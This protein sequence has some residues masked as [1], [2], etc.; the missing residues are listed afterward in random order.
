MGDDRSGTRL[1]GAPA[2]DRIT[3]AADA[4]AALHEE[5]P[6]SPGD[7]VLTVGFAPAPVSGTMD[8]M[9]DNED[10]TAARGASR[11][12]AGKRPGTFRS[13]ANRNYRLWAVG[14][15]VSNVGT[16]MQ[17]TAQ[18]WLVLTALTRHDAAAVGIVSA[19]QF[20]PLL[21]L[22]PWT[23]LAA[24][25]FDRRRL[26]IATQT[27]M[28]VLALGLG[29]LTIAGV[30]RLWEVYAFAFGLGC[31]SAFD[32]PVRQAFVSELVGEDALSNA[33]ALNSMS[34]N[35]AR[36]VGP[37]IAGLL[38]AAIG[39]GA[40]FLANAASYG[41]VLASLAFLRVGDLHGGRRDPIGPGG[42]A[43][44]FRYVGARR[45]PADHPGDAVPA[46]HVRLQLPDLHLDHVGVRFSISGPAATACWHPPW[47]SARC[48]APPCPHG[49]RGRPPACWWRAPPASGPAWWRRR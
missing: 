7:P 9:A 48:W 33:V 18:D 11:E 35:A 42:L 39:S 45:G 44:G 47:R 17:R 21:L 12:R 27:A 25:R 22:L 36:L 41:A 20:G 4:C 40:V 5:L 1:Q 3:A 15:L 38:I 24:D 26:L 30:V 13:L 28:G 34:F 32:A 49:A 29:L 43:A 14:G 23:G 6:A 37:A 46:G 2:V 16:W 19:L 31:A 10:T 8:G